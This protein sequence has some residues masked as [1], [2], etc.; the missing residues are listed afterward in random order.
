VV[1]YPVYIV[2][3]GRWQN[4]L[5]HKALNAMGVPHAIVV[6][7]HE[8]DAYR[9]ATSAEILILPERYK[10]EY[11]TCDGFGDSKSKGPGPARN[12]ALD[13]ATAGGHKRHWV[14]DDNLD[15][16]HYLNRNEKYE[17][18]CDATLRAMEDFVDRYS[19]VPL[20]GP[21]YYSFAKKTDAVP[22]FVRNTRIYSCL[23]MANDLGYRWRGR[24][25]EDTDLS[26]RILKDGWCTIQF[27]AF[28]CGKITTQRMKGGNTQ[29]FYEQEGTKAKS[30]MIADLH[31]DVARV[32]WRFNR[33]H[34]HVDYR[35]F[36]RNRLKHIDPSR[37]YPEINDYG[38]IAID[39]DQRPSAR[40]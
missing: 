20:A 29:E 5:T 8:A 39:Y 16:F 28:L 23:L 9:R 21:N 36:R 6:E 2:S 26:L 31:P 18:E 15:A 13:H 7:P 30:Q 38:L 3:K 12:F 25:N 33:W 10:A 11:D 19:N 27:N 24:Y 17:V 1:R 22:P 35:K 34:H 4:P 14:M 40:G 37:K 32:V